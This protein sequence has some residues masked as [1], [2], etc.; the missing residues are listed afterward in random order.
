[1]KNILKNAKGSSMIY[2]M[3]MMGILSVSVIIFQMSSMTYATKSYNDKMDKQAYLSARST[4]DAIYDEIV[5]ALNDTDPTQNA[6]VGNLIKAMTS[7]L[8]VGA[9]RDLS[10][11]K[12]ETFT[13]NV[14][15]VNFST[16]PNNLSF[17]TVDVTVQKVANTFEYIIAAT[18]T[19]GTQSETV[20]SV[21][22]F[23]YEL[24]SLSTGGGGSN[25]FYLDYGFGDLI[26]QSGVLTSKIDDINFSYKTDILVFDS[27]IIFK[28]DA[29]LSA[30]LQSTSDIIMWETEFNTGDDGKIT[31]LGNI[32]FEDLPASSANQIH[33]GGSFA[34]KNSARLTADIYS[35]ENL[36]AFGNVNFNNLSNEYS[37]RVVNEVLID[38]QDGGTLSLEGISIYADKITIKSGSRVI[39]N[40]AEG[41]LYANEIIIEQGVDFSDFS[42]NMYTTSGTATVNGSTSATYDGSNSVRTITSANILK[43]PTN[44]SI[45]ERKNNDELTWEIGHLTSTVSPI[46]TAPTAMQPDQ[47]Y[48]V[49]SSGYN[50]ITFSNSSFASSS[51]SEYNLMIDSST[52]A[53]DVD[54]NLLSFTTDDYAYFCSLVNFPSANFTVANVASRL[55]IS[56][57]YD[58]NGNVVN[59][60]TYL[61]AASF[62]GFYGTYYIVVKDGQTLEITG[63]D[64]SNKDVRFI[65]EGNG[66]V[67]LPAGIFQVYGHTDI[68]DLVDTTDSAGNI[69]TQGWIS[70][71]MD[72]AWESLKTGECNFTFS[73][74]SD[75]E[76]LTITSLSMLK[77]KYHT[78]IDGYYAQMSKVIANTAGVGD[79]IFGAITAP[80]IYSARDSL[81]LQI[82]AEG[83][84][85]GGDPTY[86]ATLTINSNFVV[87]GYTN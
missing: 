73:H 72:A 14:G 68:P 49:N 86:E 46:T 20:K 1:M 47:Y 58:V 16:T 66:A 70:Q 4:V 81:K 57:I 48:S 15:E 27:P 7:S 76:D 8:A 22:S 53:Y 2:V 85:G 83:D 59:S 51:A 23:E 17:G 43:P 29:T 25:V 65:L 64:I 13:I 60:G 37:I 42:G 82:D 77:S 40:G 36:Y 18:A 80:I 3:L 74:S 32:Y 21:I 52:Y 87:K 84:V 67:M 11:L 45:I 44:A 62:I 5:L 38:G 55:S 54:G 28:G 35:D 30:P 9:D 19:V 12:S 63:D 71:Y 39:S 78:K 33:T 79:F 56:D 50:I 61:N 10:A 34:I 31:S 6:K 69:I 24:Q 26:N 41:S 75:A